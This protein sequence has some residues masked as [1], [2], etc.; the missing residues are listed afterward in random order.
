M[1]AASAAAAFATVVGLL[2][3]F[4]NQRQ[5]KTDSD[6]A[7]FVAWL[8]E[9][10]H[11]ELVELLR[12]N[13]STATSI[14][15]LLNQDRTVLLEKI[16]HLD[17]TLASIASTVEGFMP[18]AASVRPGSEFSRQ[19]IRILRE[20]HV[21]GAG[22]A[23]DVSTFEGRSLLLFEGGDGAILFDEPRFID[24]DLNVLVESGLL[25]LDYNS[26]GERLYVFTRFAA[27]YLRGI[28]RGV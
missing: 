13:A 25:R 18:L 24:D 21:S 1:D 3:D 17:R 7:D 23:L 12:L 2:A 22:K 19:A 9:N 6:Y 20:F 14:K 11:S 26:K 8:A 16:E 15:A 28:P 5:H 10:R 4:T 27:D